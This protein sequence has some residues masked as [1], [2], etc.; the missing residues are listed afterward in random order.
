MLFRSRG[1]TAALLPLATG[2]LGLYLCTVFVHLSPAL[3][4]VLAAVSGMGMLA[5]HFISP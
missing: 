2:S 5:W 4:A 1:D 3:M